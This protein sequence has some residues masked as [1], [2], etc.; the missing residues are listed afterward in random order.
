[1]IVSK[2]GSLYNIINQNENKHN[3]LVYD[4]IITHFSKA[5]SLG[6]GGGFKKVLHLL[7]SRIMSWNLKFPNIF[8]NLWKKILRVENLLWQ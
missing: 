4:I 2:L 6:G 7:F 1:M 5:N 8:S 3:L